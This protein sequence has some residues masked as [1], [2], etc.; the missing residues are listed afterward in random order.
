VIGRVRAAAALWLGVAAAVAAPGGAA[1]ANGIAGDRMFPTTLIVEDTQNDDEISLPTVSWLHRGGNGDH[2][3]G[4]EL[5][6][7]GEYSRSLT[8]DL[9]VLVGGGW[10]RLS[11]GGPAQAGWDNIELGLKYRTLLNEPH[12]FLLSTALIAEIG[13]TGTK[14]VGAED[15]STVQPIVSF[16]KGFGDLPHDWDWLRP[17]A[18]TGAAGVALPAGAGPKQAIYGVTLQ[19]SLIYLDQHVGGS[20]VPGWAASLVP[21]VEFAAVSPIGR[22]DETRTTMTVNPGIAWVQGD[23]WQL[24]AEAIV[25]LTRA[26]GRGVGFVAQLHVF[27]DDVFK[28]PVFGN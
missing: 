9:T 10:R 6:I 27:L 1:M 28:T 11:A 7:T 14:R 26:T 3:A 17:A 20:A 12:E 19:Y 24:T 21:L 8:T 25:P 18:I 4:R 2:R 13:N 15:F 23:D 5:R 16:G 22:S